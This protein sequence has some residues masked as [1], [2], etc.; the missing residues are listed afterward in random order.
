M[1]C[2]RRLGFA[3]LAAAACVLAVPAWSNGDTFFRSKEIRGNPEFVIFGSV[4]DANGKYLQ[5]A[6]VIV[7]V[8]VH[9]LEFTA[10][11]D[12][13]GRYRTADVGRAIKDLGYPVDPALI[14]V[15]VEC[16][17]YRL[18]RREYRGKYG[19]KKGAVEVNFLMQKVE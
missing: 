18:L 10:D 16:P 15:A 7:S 19:Q 5:Q 4:K 2:W 14:T 12:V 1:C 13:L 17:G 6:T 3:V 8:A 9:E 11:T